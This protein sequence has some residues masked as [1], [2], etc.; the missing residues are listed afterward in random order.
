MEDSVKG[1]KKI[2]WSKQA[3]R[4]G[5]RCEWKDTSD[6]ASKNNN[7]PP[8]NH[9]F[10]SS[11]L[12]FTSL[13]VRKHESGLWIWNKTTTKHRSERTMCGVIF[14]FFMLDDDTTTINMQLR[15]LI[16]IDRL[17]PNWHKRRKKMKFRS[18]WSIANHLNY[19]VVSFNL[20]VWKRR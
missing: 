13:A 5:R 18:E 1:V 2:A 9:H 12:L 20:I 6:F 3:A 14:G 10:N 16:D 11:L 8:K 4:S 7:H 15:V 17:T 19:H